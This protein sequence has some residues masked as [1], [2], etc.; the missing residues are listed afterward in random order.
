MNL[1]NLSRTSPFSR[2]APCLAFAL[3]GC[4]DPTGPAMEA[5]T[6]DESAAEGNDDA[7]SATSGN[8]EGGEEETGGDDSPPV[9]PC[10]DGVCEPTAKIEL[11]VEVLG[12]EGVIVERTFALNAEV[13]A[14]ADHLSLRINNLGYENKGSVRVNDGPW[15]SLAHDTVTVEPRAM[16]R[17]GMQHA[18]FGT[19]W[20]ELPASDFV[21]GENVVRFRFDLSNAISIGYRVIDLRVESAAGDSLLPEWMKLRDDPSKWTAPIEGEEAIAAGRELWH[22]APLWSH[23]LPEERTGFWYDKVI[24][25]RR[26]IRARCADCHTRDGRDLELFSYSNLSIVERA[27]FHGLSELEGQQIAAYIRSLSD[28]IPEVERW[29]RPW[30]PPFQPGPAVADLPIEAWPAGAGLDAI[31]DAD[32]D[33]APYMFGEEITEASVHARFDSTKTVDRTT[34][35]LAIQ[36]PDWKHWL[37]LVHP[38]DA[39][40]YDGWYD[41]LEP[42][43]EADCR[44]S[45]CV[46][47]VGLAYE[48][49]RDFLEAQ[50]PKERPIED[51]MRAVESYWYA[52]RFFF[53]SGPSPK[54]WRTIDSEANLIGM[55][56]NAA[57][58]DME[59]GA[60]SVARLMAVK[61]FEVHHEFGLSDYAATALGAPEDEVPTRQW[62][63]DNYQIFEIPP[64]FTA[65][66]MPNP[67][68][69]KNCNYFDGQPYVTGKFESTSWY[70]LQSIVNGGAGQISHNSPVDYNYQ[71]DHTMA[72]SFLSGE[73]EPLRMYHQ[74][75]TMYQTRTWSGGDSP[76]TGKG[77]RIRVMGPWVFFGVSQK[78]ELQGWELGDI[79]SQLDD[80]QPG[81]KKWTLDA[82]LEQFLNEMDRPFNALESWDRVAPNGTD[83]ALDPATKT[84]ADII[85]IDSKDFVFIGG[86]WA[87][88]YYA[89]VPWYADAGVECEVMERYLAWGEAAWPLLDWSAARSEL[90]ATAELHLRDDGV[91][92]VLGSPGAAPEVVWSVDGET[93]QSAGLQLPTSA[94]AAGSL[95]EASVLSD[96]ACLAA[97]RRQITAQLQVP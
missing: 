23:Y 73:R 38:M 47:H 93:V 77:F 36:F 4:T 83:N 72:A 15:V 84:M 59:F 44:G 86:R 17:G 31:L 78:G 25:S 19:M 45:S 11:P 91:H 74:L 40:N 87:D 16:A 68:G 30:N 2:L 32:A 34:L 43:F 39:Y 71:Q 48:A 90:R 75:N 49:F 96:D 8:G 79:P 88:K 6:G 58:V 22:E 61:Y 66:F 53:A 65:C 63:G 24:E 37:P 85:P 10:E 12:E 89:M 20:V 26:Q 70:H 27:K 28:T 54:H 29:G 80:I 94:Y 92:L 60:T 21:E 50:P 1:M 18:G 82:L 13:A 52:H 55:G 35:P 67:T 81:L 95:V 9:W 51:L 97:E 14:A 7:S 64:H 42:S 41:A 57:N 46:W 62:L 3:V 76:N 33:M 5:E 56:P 69:N